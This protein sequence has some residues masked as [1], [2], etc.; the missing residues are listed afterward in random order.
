[1]FL[2]PPKED[3]QCMAMCVPYTCWTSTTCS[4]W[5]ENTFLVQYIWAKPSSLLFTTAD[6]PSQEVGFLSTSLSHLKV[7]CPL[8][9][10]S[11][12]LLQSTGMGWSIWKEIYLTLEHNLFFGGIQLLWMPQQ[13]VQMKCLLP[14]DEMN[15]SP[16]WCHLLDETH[17]ILLLWKVQH[18]SL[19]DYHTNSGPAGQA[20]S[21]DVCCK[22]ESRRK[23][24]FT[25]MP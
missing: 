21:V 13:L 6:F 1:M 24:S 8:H 14:R 22:G 3:T 12:V 18:V 11:R 17:D 10:F 4:A 16:V 19:E 9:V 23:L 25:P 5:G 7:R 15:L 2:S 20:E